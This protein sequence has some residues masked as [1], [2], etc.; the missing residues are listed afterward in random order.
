MR[1]ERNPSQTNAEDVPIQ[2]ERRDGEMKRRDMKKGMQ[3]KEEMKNKEN[4]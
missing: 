2:R 1:T 4:L 3:R